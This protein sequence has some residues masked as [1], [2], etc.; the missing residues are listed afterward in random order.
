MAECLFSQRASQQLVPPFDK[1]RVTLLSKHC[2]TL[3]P[4]NNL[5]VLER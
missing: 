4:H 3:Q 1:L 5:Q 2:S